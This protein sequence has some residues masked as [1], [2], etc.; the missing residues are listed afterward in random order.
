[1]EINLKSMKCRII[2]LKK[3]R[4]KMIQ[5]VEKN[6]KIEFFEKQIG[7]LGFT[8]IILYSICFFVLKNILEKK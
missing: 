3:K 4:I 5:V 1:M 2:Q 6:W 7:E 8:L